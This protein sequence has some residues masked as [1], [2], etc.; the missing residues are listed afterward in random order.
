MRGSGS[1]SAR[2]SA[3]SRV[4]SATAC[5]AIATEEI[6]KERE[7]EEERRRKVKEEKLCTDSILFDKFSFCTQLNY[8]YNHIQYC[9]YADMLLKKLI[10]E[11]EGRRK[12][13]EKS[14]VLIQFDKT[15]NMYKGNLSYFLR[16]SDKLQLR[17]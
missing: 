16:V 6:G 14:S 4:M 5:D 1:H 3:R 11:K 15:H 17:Q 10:A 8:T 13:G 7:R 9:N 12:K 2:E